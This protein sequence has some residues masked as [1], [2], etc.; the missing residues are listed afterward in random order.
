MINEIVKDL[1]LGFEDHRLQSLTCHVYQG[2]LPPML[3]KRRWKKWQRQ[4]RWLSGTQKRARCTQCPAFDWAVYQKG[5][6]TQ[7]QN[8][9][10]H[11]SNGQF[12]CPS[13]SD[14][15]QLVKERMTGISLRKSKLGPYKSLNMLWCLNEGVKDLVKQRC[16]GGLITAS[17][18][19][20]GQGAS[21]GARLCI[22]TRH[23]A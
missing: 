6:L 21:V 11:L 18:S 7:H 15:A 4:F 5:Q 10:L 19:Q 17:V 20:D 3:D 14:F 13:V 9:K 23:R 22:V 2:S 12:A 8:S 16:N 1:T